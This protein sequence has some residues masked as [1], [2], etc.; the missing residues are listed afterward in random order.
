ML[1][2]MSRSPRQARI[3]PAA[4]PRRPE[5]R[6]DR[7]EAHEDGPDGEREGAHAGELLP[8]VYAMPEVIHGDG[9]DADW[10]LWDACM[11]AW[12][13]QGQPPAEVSPV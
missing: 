3:K 8:D 2:I 6:Q 5:D 11:A 12:D 9:G 7:A 13:Q 10:A 1:K 4:A